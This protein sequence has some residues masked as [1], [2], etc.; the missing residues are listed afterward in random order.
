[1]KKEM[2]SSMKTILII[3]AEGEGEGEGEGEEEARDEPVDD[4]GQRPL[5]AVGQANRD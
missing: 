1:M 3:S 4:L 2:I 5:V